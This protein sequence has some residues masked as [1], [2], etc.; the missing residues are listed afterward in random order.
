LN[1]NILGSQQVEAR[2]AG[3]IL[4]V[5][6]TAAASR[7]SLAIEKLEKRSEE[8][9]QTGERF[10]IAVTAEQLQ[11]DRFSRKS[12]NDHFSGNSRTKLRI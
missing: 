6:A 11:N 3:I 2:K 10:T 5:P 7:A 9:C 4:R 12:E 1:E 8:K